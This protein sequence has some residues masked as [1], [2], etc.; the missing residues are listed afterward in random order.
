MP[1]EAGEIDTGFEIASPLPL[2]TVA[3][4]KNDRE[5]WPKDI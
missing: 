3:R 4:E 5:V 2:C 1:R